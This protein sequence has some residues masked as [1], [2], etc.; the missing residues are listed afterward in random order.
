MNRIQLV[1]R[2]SFRGVT[3]P[4]KERQRF[5]S[6]IVRQ[7][8]TEGIIYETHAHRMTPS[9]SEAIY[10]PGPPKFSVHSLLWHCVR[11]RGVEPRERIVG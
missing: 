10:V 2:F 1:S 5:L 9:R 11:A 6:T 3:K 8:T 7:N 4:H